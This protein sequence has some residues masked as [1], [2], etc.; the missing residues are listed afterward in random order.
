MFK[1]KLKELREK[2]GISQQALA[3]KLFVSRSA[4]AKWENGNGIPSDVNLEAICKFF[5]VK[6]EW[7]LDRV[8]I[9]EEV[10]KLNSKNKKIIWFI[11][12]IIMPLVLVILSLFPFFE[13][14][15]VKEAIYIS[16]FIP[17]RGVFVSLAKDYNYYIVVI[18]LLIYIYQFTFSFIYWKKDMRKGKMIQ[19]INLSISTICFIITFIIAYKV[20]IDN[21]FHL[22]CA[23]DIFWGFLFR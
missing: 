5:D 11:L 17:P 8:D 22:F 14:G 20:S 12:G 1:D 21:G 7:L 13:W 18:T 23:D 19:I 15:P 6:E 3:D 9:K 4:V 10:K 2:E 16:L